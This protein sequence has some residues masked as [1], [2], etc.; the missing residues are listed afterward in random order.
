MKD[1]SDTQKKKKK[2][3]ALIVG[4]IAACLAFSCAIVW[5]VGK[6]LF[7][8]YIN[9][10]L[11]YR[12][13]QDFIEK[14]NYDNALLAINDSIKDKENDGESYVLRA[15][16]YDRMGDKVKSKQDLDY[17]AKHKP[18][19]AFDLHH[20]GYLL[21]QEDNYDANEVVRL[22]TLY[23]YVNPKFAAAYANRALAYCQLKQ[24]DKAIADCNKGLAVADVVADSHQNLRSIRADVYLQA[25]RFAECIADCQLLLN[26]K[27]FAVDK[28]IGIQATLLEAYN[29]S[30]QYAK[31]LKL[32]EEAL[33]LY[34]DNNY[35]DTEI[36]LARAKALEKIPGSTPLNKAEA[37]RL[38][39]EV[40]DERAQEKTE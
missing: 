6:N 38:R 15:D 31:A 30:A 5:E 34:K 33:K 27:T 28:R 18:D 25:G 10:N 32:S 40:A 7:A 11:F 23:Q 2:R 35:D 8:T 14:K 22:E 37:S 21:L 4:T 19:L 24:F 12:C 29:S 13:A 3:I 26:D 39:K 16:L 36:K 20:R 9:K 1:Q 17:I